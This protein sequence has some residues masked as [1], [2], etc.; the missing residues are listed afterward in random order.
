MHWN[1]GTQEVNRQKFDIGIILFLSFYI[2]ITTLGDGV[3]YNESIAFT[4]HV[5][6]F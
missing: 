6:L 5:K 3:D 4:S 2:M 1:I